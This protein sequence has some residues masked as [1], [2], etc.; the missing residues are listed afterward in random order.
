MIKILFYM[1][2]LSEGGAEKVLRNLVNAMDQTQFDITVQTTWQEPHEQYLNPGIHYKYCYKKRNRLTRNLFR[3]E[4]AI[5]LVYPLHIR[6][7]YDIEAAY[8]ECAPTKIMAASTNRKA[9]KLAWVHCD[10]KKKMSDVNSFREKACG[11]YRKFDKVVCVSGN[12]QDSYIDL[13]GASP[14]AVV[15]YNVIDDTEIFEKS[16]KSCDSIQRTGD[17]TAVSV[18][19]LTAQKGYDNLFKVHSRLIRE[20][21]H[22]QLYILGEGSDRESLQNYIE[23]NHL[24]DTLHLIGFK[25]NPYCY[26]NQADFLIC[27]SRYEGFST[28]L[29]EGM[30]LGK[31]AVT[32]DC[33]GMRELLEDSKYGL[34]TENSDDGLYEG[35]K[36][37][38]TDS[39]L[40]RHYSAQAQKRGQDFRKEY[41]VRQTEEFF[42][43]VLEEK[44]P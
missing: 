14:E 44:E 18:G 28:F 19:R 6:G 24:E 43:K 17:L 29:T 32:T 22:Y 20:G 25:D 27:S 15:L 34:I 8:L 39:N 41:L 2:N 9:V 16:R 13:F 23:E 42:K 4:A 35:M 37:M 3:M 5:G 33:T 38:L 12:V 26:M 1:D 31:A 30:I 21:Y 7:D 40:R 10:L 36:R 11:W